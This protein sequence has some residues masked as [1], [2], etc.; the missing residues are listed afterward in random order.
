MSEGSVLLLE[1]LRFHK[2]EEANCFGFAKEL[3]S[4]GNIYINDAF[5]SAHRFHASTAGVSQFID[6]SVAGLLMEKELDFLGNKI[7][8]PEHPFV[9]ILRWSKGQ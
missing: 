7:T 1:N 8:T 2:E 6:I 5:G 3:A 9:V 4:L